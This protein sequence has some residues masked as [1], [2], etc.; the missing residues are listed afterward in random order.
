MYAIRSYYAGYV[1]ELMRFT[2]SGN[3]WVRRAAAVSLVMLVRKGLCKSEA[4][5]VAENLLSDKDDMVQKGYGW[6]LKVASQTYEKE[7]YNFV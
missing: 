6:L 4:F 5:K 1:D 2:K 3:R 7:S